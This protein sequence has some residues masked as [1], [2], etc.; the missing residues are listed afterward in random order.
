MKRRD[1]PINM[2][3]IEYVSTVYE[4]L[5]QKDILDVLD[6][7]LENAEEY[8]LSYIFSDSSFFIEYK[9]GE[10]YD[11]LESGEYG[12]Y[13]KKGIKGI[14]YV[15]AEDTWVYGNYTVNEYGNVSLA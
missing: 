1:Y 13:K 6:E 8:G 3:G 11:V 4:T 14:L 5:K 2:D 10:T 9:N 7:M 12:T 15:N